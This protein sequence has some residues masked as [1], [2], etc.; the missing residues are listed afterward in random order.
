MAFCS[1]CGVEIVEGVKFCSSCGKAIN[2]VSNDSVALHSDTN[3]TKDKN[4]KNF[5]YAFMGCALLLCI[6]FFTL[7]LVQC[8]QD[9]SYTA[10]GWEIATGTG[11]LFSEK[12]K[13]YPLA[14]LLIII[15][16]ILPESV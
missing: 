13:G 14:F 8:S 7:P 3:E 16:V 1:N 2:G 11:K 15:P 4:V 10:S 12:D 9:S 5:R 6:F